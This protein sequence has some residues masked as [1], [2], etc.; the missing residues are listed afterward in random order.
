MTP[1]ELNEMIREEAWAERQVAEH[2][3]IGGAVWAVLFELAV[4]VGALL[5]SFRE[6]IANYIGPARLLF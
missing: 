1:F 4:I 2:N 6:S 3:G 5:W